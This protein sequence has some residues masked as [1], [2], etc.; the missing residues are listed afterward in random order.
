[1][2]RWHMLR[3]LFVFVSA[4]A[5]FAAT[6]AAGINLERCNAET[7]EIGRGDYLLYVGIPLLITFLAACLRLYLRTKGDFAKIASAGSVS[8][9]PDTALVRTLRTLGDESAELLA[10]GNIDGAR[11][12]SDAAQRITEGKAVAK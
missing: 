8:A 11:A 2:N 9:V 4:V 3:I 7:D 12:I 10:E 1:M 5:G 6:F